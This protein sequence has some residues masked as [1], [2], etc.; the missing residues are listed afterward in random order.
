M[1]GASLAHRAR[2]AILESIL[3][4]RF[5]GSRLPPENELAEM[6]GVSRTTVRSALQSLAQHGVLTRSP[7][8]GTQVHGRLSP[9]M[10]ALQR[11]IGFARLLEEQG[12][13]VD[14]VTRA[15]LTTRP[16]AEV[17][18]ALNVAPRAGVYEVSRLFVASGKPAVWAIN[19]L[20]AELFATKPTDQELAQSPFDMGELLTG[21]PVD[22]AVVELVP[23]MADAAVVAELQ[24]EAGEPYL[25]LKETHYSD[26]GQTLGFSYIHVNDRFVRFRLY[27]GA[28]GA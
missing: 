24:L 7:R 1:G 8:R 21:G 22:H 28:D 18:H 11:L 14:V 13:V 26:T 2:E 16:P 5:A 20:A 25:L 12:Y 15:T 9:S 4:G 27:R 23:A 19:Y 3:D 6:L 17:S 10:V